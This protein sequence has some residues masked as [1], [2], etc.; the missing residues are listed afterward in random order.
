[1]KKVFIGVLAALMLFAFTACEQKI[2]TYVELVGVTAE[3]SKDV[4]YPGEKFD[5]STVTVYFHYSDKTTQSFPGSQFVW[6]ADEEGTAM[7]ANVATGFTASVNFT[8]S[9]VV[10][11]ESISVDVSG[12]TSPVYAVDKAQSPVAAEIKVTGK[13]SDGTEAVVTNATLSFVDEDGTAVT[14][15]TA[16][17]A[18]YVKAAVGSVSGTSEKAIST[19]ADKVTGIKVTVASD[20]KPYEHQKLNAT[21]VTVT[22]V[23]ASGLDGSTIATNEENNITV[24]TELAAGKDASLK[25]GSNTVNVT[26]KM[27]ESD[28]DNAKFVTYKGTATVTAAEDYP[29]AIAIKYT[30]L[31]SDE[32]PIALNPGATVS[33]NFF[34]VTVTTWK[35]TVTGIYNEGTEED[36]NQ[37]Y[38]LSSSEFDLVYDEF[39]TEF[40]KSQLDVN[41]K[42]VSD[43]VDSP[44]TTTAAQVPVN[45]NSDGDGNQ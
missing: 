39:T 32:E 16:E 18:V 6:V 17:T 5:P 45:Q 15:F 20:Y 38:V 7:V 22:G 29:T 26:V 35:S 21:K 4:Y 10:T 3:N 31:D 36:E 23:M 44:V 1:M 19:V 24:T 42:F 43:Y 37:R 14:D 12:Y 34:E 33:K 11:Y 2:P 13:L 40:A 9:M 8:P 27:P 41:A 28:A 30:N 25:E